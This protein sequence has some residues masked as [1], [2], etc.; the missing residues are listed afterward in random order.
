VRAPTLLLALAALAAC[1]GPSSS[2]SVRA[3]TRAER[4]APEGDP[5]LRTTPQIPA[6]VPSEQVLVRAHRAP[7]G[8]AAIVEFLS[9]GLTEQQ[10][11]ALRVGFEQGTLQL[12]KEGAAGEESWTTTLVPKP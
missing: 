1:A 8:R 10:R 3:P 11:T 7:D 9:E 12:S 6:L 5:A 4:A 2:T